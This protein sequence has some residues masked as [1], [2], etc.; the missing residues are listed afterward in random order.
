MPSLTVARVPFS[1]QRA[2]PEKCFDLIVSALGGENAAT[3]QCV[4]SSQLGAGR[5]T[6]GMVIASIVKAAQMITKLNKVR[7]GMAKENVDS[8]LFVRWL[9]PE[10]QRRPGQ[11]ISSRPSSKIRCRARTTRILSCEASLT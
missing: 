4:F 8:F 11:K 6:L 2:I 1:E 5:S 10:W 9:R 7:S 3:T